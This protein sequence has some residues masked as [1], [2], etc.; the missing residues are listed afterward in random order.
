MAPDSDFEEHEWP[1]GDEGSYNDV[2]SPIGDSGVEIT[3]MRHLERRLDKP[4]SESLAKA[5]GTM[6]DENDSFALLFNHE[7]TEKSIR[8][9]GSGALKVR[10]VMEHLSTYHN[11]VR[12]FD[13]SDIGEA[14]L[15]TPGGHGGRENADED[16][17]TGED[18]DYFAAIE[19]TLRVADGVDAGAA[20]DSLVKMAVEH[21][22][23]MKDKALLSSNYIGLLWKTTIRCRTNAP[24]L[25]VANKLK[26][27]EPGLLG[28]SIQYMT[29]YVD[30]S[31]EKDEKFAVV[32]SIVSIGLTG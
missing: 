10:S 20:L 15:Y 9:L 8:D 6:D 7:Y 12:M 3:R 1:F 4:L 5:I 21:A 32:A 26:T 17:D 25:A 19:M 24:F 30:N 29:Q 18:V 28:P 2:P 14:V 27:A 22:E 11:L 23:K 13:W 16:V 31:D